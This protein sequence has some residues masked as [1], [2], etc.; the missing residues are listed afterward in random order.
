[1]V[2]A[3]FE[4]LVAPPV[5]VGL[6]HDDIALHE[7]PL[8]D[9]VDIKALVFGL[10]GTDRDILEIGKDCHDRG[11]LIR[12]HSYDSRWNSRLAN[13]ETGGFWLICRPEVLRLPA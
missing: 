2:H 9:L 12:W 4:L 10:L 8:D 5:A 1:L 11:L 3:A 6:A 7:D 13:A